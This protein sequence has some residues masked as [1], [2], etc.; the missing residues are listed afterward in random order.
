VH[1][2]RS[3]MPATADQEG[4]GT[5]LFLHDRL[6]LAELWKQDLTI[7]SVASEGVPNAVA[8]RRVA[9]LLDYIGMQSAGG[10]A[11][12]LDPTLEGVLSAPERELASALRGLV[13]SLSDEAWGTPAGRRLHG[14]LQEFGLRDWPEA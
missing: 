13:G 14:L 11:H 2:V 7:T 4:F 9:I 8:A 5:A 3:A 12:L 6:L 1:D 10:A